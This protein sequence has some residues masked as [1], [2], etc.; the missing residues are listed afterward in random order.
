[1]TTGECQLRIR[2]YNYVKG[3]RLFYQKLS[4]CARLEFIYAQVDEMRE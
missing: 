2:Q 3:M 1:M 4:F